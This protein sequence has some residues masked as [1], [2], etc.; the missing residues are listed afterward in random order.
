[1]SRVRPDARDYKERTMTQE[2]QEMVR[3]R[4]LDLLLEQ[5]EA[6]TY[7]SSTMLDI[8]ERLLTPEEVPE[9][10]ELLLAKV[11]ADRYPSMSLVRRLVAL[12]GT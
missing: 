8:I 2:P 6:D 3:T 9:Y 7:P 11:E 12:A 4:T 5:V 1:M 10:A